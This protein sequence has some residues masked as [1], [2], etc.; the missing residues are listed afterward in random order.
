LLASFTNKSIQDDDVHIRKHLLS[1]YRGLCENGTLALHVAKKGC[2]VFMA[3][4]VE[5]DIRDVVIEN[6]SLNLLNFHLWGH[7][8]SLVYSSTVDNIENLLNGIVAGFQTIGI[9][10]GSRD[11]L[12]M[13]LR[14]AF[15]Q[16][17][18]MW[19]FTSVVILRAEC[20]MHETCR[21]LCISR[22]MLIQTIFVN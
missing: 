17:M 13:P 10:L 2:A 12:H 19:G 3:P 6:H 20:R 9:M 7:W 4:K 16:E 14:I 21:K 1:I 18:D 22:S 5:E 15:R 8:K 11:E